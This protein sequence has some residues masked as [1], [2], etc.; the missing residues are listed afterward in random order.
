MGLL[1]PRGIQAML[2]PD[3]CRAARG[4]LNWTQHELARRANIGLSTIKKFEA[5]RSV[6]IKNNV[7]AIDAVFAKAGIMILS[8]DDGGPGVL[9]KRLRPHGYTP[10]KGLH[11]EIDYAD[12]LLEGPDNEF[13]LWFLATERALEHLAGRKVVDEADAKGIAWSNETRIVDTV[14]QWLE[15]RGL[16]SKGGDVRVLDAEA[17]N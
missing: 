1:I 6:P 4:L 10:G 7:L 8:N 17:F 13:N 14:I 12:C 3:T 9:L 15:T 5:G 16:S 11:F 2:D